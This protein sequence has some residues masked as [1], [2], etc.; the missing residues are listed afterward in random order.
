MA[1]EPTTMPVEMVERAARALYNDSASTSGTENWWPLA[2]PDD[3]DVYRRAARVVLSAALQGDYV[4]GVLYRSALLAEHVILAD[5]EDQA[6]RKVRFHRG[7]A[8]AT[9]VRAPRGEWE[10]VPD[11]A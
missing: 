6:R 2:R 10:E 9:V 1:D 5:D 11:G 3:Q 4:W 7:Q 8:T